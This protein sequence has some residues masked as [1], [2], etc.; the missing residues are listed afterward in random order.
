MKT[1]DI[2]NIAK[3][4]KN[5]N[6][7]IIILIDNTFATPYITNPLLLGADVAYHSLTKYTGG[8]SDLIMGALVFKDK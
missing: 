2:Q 7:N 1:L 8:H 4:V 6:K 3:V 5:I